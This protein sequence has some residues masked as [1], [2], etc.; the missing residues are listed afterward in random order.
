LLDGSGLAVI[1]TSQHVGESLGK[2][3]V[4]KCRQEDRTFFRCDRQWRNVIVNASPTEA[5]VL[6]VRKS[7]KTE[8]MGNAGIRL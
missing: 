2:P 4:L 5:N 7:E 1:Q 6:T 3:K 8:I